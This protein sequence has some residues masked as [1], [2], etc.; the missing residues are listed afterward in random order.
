MLGGW[1]EVYG[2]MVSVKVGFRYIET[3]TFDRVFWIVTSTNL[4]ALLSS[5]SSVK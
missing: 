3:L 5:I 1:L 4:I 2:I